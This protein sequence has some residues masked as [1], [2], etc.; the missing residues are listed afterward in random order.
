MRGMR[1][2]AEPGAMML[3]CPSR[4]HGAAEHGV[5]RAAHPEA[6]V[7]VYQDRADEY[8]GAYGMQHRGESHETHRQ[9]EVGTPHRE[10]GHEQPQQTY[11]EHEEQ[12][13][14]PAVVAADLR[15]ALLAI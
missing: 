9:S 3:P 7:D 11:D 5:H 12:E 10:P 14:L 6:G 15:Q 8:Q 1:D 4:G 13:L 2:L